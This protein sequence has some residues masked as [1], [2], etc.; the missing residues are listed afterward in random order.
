[1]ERVARSRG[2]LTVPPASVR[3]P[4]EPEPLR[5]RAN[6]LEFAALA[7]GP[8]DGP[9][10]L[11][12]H[13]YPDTARTWR[14]IAPGLAER[15]RRVVA[16]YLRGY[17]PSDLAPDGSYRLG[18]LI[19]D[20]LALHGA[21]GGDERAVLIGHDWGAA[22][23]HLVAGGPQCPFARVVTLAIPPPGPLA[24]V[25]RDP[26]LLLRQL[27]FSWY[28][29]FQQIPGLSERSLPWLIPHLWRRWS[30]SYDGAADVTEV[31]ACLAAPDARTAALRYYRHAV[32]RPRPLAAGGRGAERARVLSGSRVPLLVLHGDE[33]GCVRPEAARRAAELLREP[34]MFVM[35]PGAGHFLQLERPEAVLTELDRFLGSVV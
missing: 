30:P 31:L 19:R 2:R 10:A 15:G 25:L 26:R 27:R 18:A 12:L 29:A 22:V 5:V 7:W 3:R 24:A 34:A 33:D 32:R 14:R 35:V 11:C 8:A 23:A 6:G 13:G 4:G 20:A 9:L 1:M 21:L 16:P 17:P 28:M